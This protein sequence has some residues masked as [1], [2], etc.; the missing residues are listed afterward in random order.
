L[1]TKCEK[2]LRKVEAGGVGIFTG[3]ENTQL[4]DFSTPKTQNTAKV[5][6]TG[7]YLERGVFSSSANSV[8]FFWNE[9]RSQTGRINLNY[10]TCYAGSRTIP[11]DN[12]RLLGFSARSFVIS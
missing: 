2:T 1:L 11:P 4:I 12:R 5:R 6:P 10:R 3:I 7:T 9:K 8:R